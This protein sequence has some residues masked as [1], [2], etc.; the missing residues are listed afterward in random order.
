VVLFG[1][2][3]PRFEMYQSQALAKKADVML[4]AQEGEVLQQ[5]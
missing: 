3:L 1:E 5:Y 4:I 2:G